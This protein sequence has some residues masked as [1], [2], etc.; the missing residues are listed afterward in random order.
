LV[1]YPFIQVQPGKEF[2]LGHPE[3]L[4]W[5]NQ[6]FEAAGQAGVT[7][8]YVSSAY[9]SMA[10]Q[11]LMWES[12]G[13]WDQTRVAPPG[14]SEHQ[15]GLAFDL[16]TSPTIRSGDGQPG[17]ATTPASGWVRQNA[18]RFGFVNT[19]P[20]PGI[21]G[22]EA[23]HWHWRY[24]GVAISTQLYELGYLKPGSAINPIEFYA[25]RMR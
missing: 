19:Y 20:R 16:S 9:R 22:I 15:S 1:S 4:A 6:L 18:H 21:D 10:T 2:M 23:E 3:A 12:A 24:V 14:T 11:T 8:L 13:G 7:P 25:E 5:L 17:F